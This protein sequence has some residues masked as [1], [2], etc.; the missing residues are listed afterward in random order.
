MSFFNEEIMYDYMN[1]TDPKNSDNIVDIALRENKIKYNEISN[2]Y[3]IYNK[4][5]IEKHKYDI[6]DLTSNLCDYLNNYLRSSLLF[7]DNIDYIII[8]RKKF[9]SEGRILLT[10]DTVCGILIAQK[11]ECTEYPDYWT[12]RLICN[13]SGS[14]CKNYATKLL[15]A[16]MLIL[17]KMKE[18]DPLNYQ[19]YGV[20]ELAGAYDNL[21]GYCTYSKLGFIENYKFK[22]AAFNKNNL[23]MT[24]N[25]DDITIEDIYN[26][27][28][29]NIRFKQN[30]STGESEKGQKRPICL[31]ENTKFKNSIIDKLKELRAH[32][33]SIEKTYN[34]ETL[35]EEE[36]K[37]M[38]D[39]IEQD[40]KESK[41]LNEER[42]KSKGTIAEKDINEL[43]ERRKKLEE[44]EDEREKR[45]KEE[46]EFTE[47]LEVLGLETPKESKIDYRLEVDRTP[48]EAR[49]TDV[50]PIAS[51]KIFDPEF[52]ERK[53]LELLKELGMENP[54][55]EKELGLLTTEPP[56][57]TK[58]KYDSDEEKNYRI[59]LEELGIEESKKPIP[60]KK[61]FDLLDELETDGRNK[62]KKNRNKSNK[63]KKR[64]KKKNRR[65]YLKK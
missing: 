50:L 14:M 46:R 62:L 40:L 4:E 29:E 61:R 51:K 57:P 23:L 20:L 9:N 13:L 34:E 52:E 7:V 38:R 18:K 65:R 60:T 17:V 35:A 36:Q 26:T 15:G 28:K 27:V 59:L 33:L 5:T 3:Y 24:S 21:A 11:G 39:I 6:V 12:V 19:K 44:E 63:S 10:K 47:M 58:K 55:I 32:S 43:L 30:K 42:R 2:Y 37:I 31:Y 64:S 53:Y 56:R 1:I 48:K 8:G 41:K 45:E 25:I 22:C 16:Y 54:V 49:K